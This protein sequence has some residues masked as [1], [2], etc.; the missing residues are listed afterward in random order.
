VC[1]VLIELLSGDND[2]L[3]LMGDWLLVVKDTSL[4]FFVLPIVVVV[5]LSMTL[6]YDSLSS[7]LLPPSARPDQPR[8]P[9]T[10]TGSRRCSILRTVSP[11]NMASR[12]R[13][14][15]Q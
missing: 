6:P 11:S 8:R 2:P 12:L 5:V 9:G 10:H 3:P 1:K 4:T 14:S 13:G 15:S 7:L